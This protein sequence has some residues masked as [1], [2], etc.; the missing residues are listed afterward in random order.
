MNKVQSKPSENASS[1]GR[2]AF[3]IQHAFRVEFRKKHGMAGLILFAVATIY[4]CYQVTGRRAEME[5]W[6]ALVWVVLLFSAFNA[7]AKSWPDDEE[8]FRNY[9]K[10]VVRPQEWILARMAYFSLIFTALTGIVFVAFSLFMGTEFIPGWRSLYFLAGMEMTALA[11]ASLLSMIQ[12]IA[13]R[14]GGGFSLIAVLGLPLIIPV[15][16]IS[17]R[18]GV[19]ILHGIAIM[20]TVQNLLFLATLTA[21]FVGFGYILFPYLWRD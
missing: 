14:A 8:S 10:H 21:G 15:V 4:A 17:T 3:L 6:N 5:S 20:D 13:I 19:D 1:L 7:I 12:S 2:V 18:F 11:L 9:L 16:I